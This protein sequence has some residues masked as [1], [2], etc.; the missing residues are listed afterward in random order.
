MIAAMISRPTQTTSAFAP[1]TRAADQGSGTKRRAF[2]TACRRFTVP[3]IGLLVFLALGGTAVARPAPAAPSIAFP[4]AGTLDAA[5][6][7][8]LNAL[9]KARATYEIAMEG[10]RKS[11]R[12]R[13]DKEFERAAAAAK[14]SK[15][16]APEVDAAKAKLDAF[17]A[18]GTIEGLTDAG[19]LEKRYAQ[20]SKLLADAYVDAETG[21]AKSDRDLSDAISREYDVFGSH[22]DLNPWGKNVLAAPL[23]LMPGGKAASVEV[24]TA[25]GYRVQIVGTMTPRTDGAAQ[26]ADA[27]ILTLRVPLPGGKQIT[28]PARAGRDGKVLVLLTVNADAVAADLGAVRP[29]DMTKAEPSTEKVLKLG[30]VGEQV[31]IERVQFKP[32]IDGAPP[33]MPEPSESKPK[34][35]STP[36]TTSSPGSASSAAA[37]QQDV[38]RTGAEL[39][40]SVVNRNNNEAVLEAE[41]IRLT[42]DRLVL[43]TRRSGNSG[44][45]V[46]WVF[47]R[48]GESLTL[49]D[50]TPKGGTGRFRVNSG[51]GKI[52]GDSISFNA[53]FERINTK[54]GADVENNRYKLKKE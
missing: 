43:E 41:I 1:H 50:M 44:Q 6:T 25:R 47:E 48:A 23:A 30:A 38:L 51:S 39:R 10:I 40:G 16:A 3:T 4:A 28:I 29:V 5:A 54:G 24:S 21:T 18:A 42:A 7:R 9:D 13:L 35:P 53:R 45:R 17:E 8:A 52:Q 26:P 31:T 11:A 12:E 14:K 22:A 32:M 49:K 27:A 33:E 37:K 20:A 15:D 46:E 2:A 34:A 19:A 36:R